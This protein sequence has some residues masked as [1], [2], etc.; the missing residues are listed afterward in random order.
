MPFF[1]ALPHALRALMRVPAFSV[2]FVLILAL[3]IAANTT[4][5]TLV[6][7]LLLHPFPY[8]NPEQL[9]MIWQSNPALGGITA[10]RVP[11][12]WVDFEAWRAQNHSFEAMEA[13]QVN[14][15]YNLTGRSVPEHLTAARATPRLF[16]MLGQNPVLGRGFLPGD[17]TPGTN[18]TV[19]LTYGFWKKHF[20]SSNP[21]GEKLLLDGVPYT[22]IGV[23]PREFHLPA[24]FEGISEYKPDVWVPL[25]KPSDT[26]PSAA[27]RRRLR[28]CAR[29]K[30]G[31]SLAQATADL[32][33]IANQLAQEDPDLNQGYSVNAYSL[34]VESIDPD[35][36]S[37]IR[38][39]SL[40]ALFVL[41]LACTNLAGLMLL[42]A[43]AR[44]KN[45]AIMAA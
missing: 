25:P 20:G 13:F 12:T 4:I 43:A 11:A 37:D 17:D 26:D 33:G 29:L 8:S 10:K 30:P 7:E 36:R 14:V 39:L 34:E 31:V 21:V 2:V 18:P 35:L 16:Q 44:R 5:F 27:R 6:D 28:V 22:I 19:V 38:A 32:K 45:M 42:R 41:L 1:R 3:G 40:A 9:V 24:L 23:L 15:G